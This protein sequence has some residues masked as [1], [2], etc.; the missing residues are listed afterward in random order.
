MH[1]PRNVPV[2]IPRGS[3]FSVLLVITPFCGSGC[4]EWR[5]ARGG[6]AGGAR[7]AVSVY[8]LGTDD[9]EVVDVVSTPEG[10][11][12]HVVSPSIACETDGASSFLSVLVFG[13]ATTDAPRERYL[14]DLGA[15]ES[16]SVAGDP[17]GVY[18]LVTRKHAT[19]P[20][21][22]PGSVL[23][24][25]EG[26]IVRTLETGPSPDAI[27]ISNDGEFAV[28]ACEGEVPDPKDCPGEEG[29]SDLPGSIHI[30]DLRG[31]PESL[32]PV[33]EIGGAAIAGRISTAP[34]GR[35][36][37]AP[38]V[39]PEF[40]AI[41][42]DSRLALVALQ[43]QSAVAVIDLG[44]LRHGTASVDAVLA[45]MV[46][47]Q[48]DH[49][50][51][52]KSVL[53]GT[54]PDGIAISPDGAFAITAN[55]AHPKA[56][57]LQGI[58]ILDLRGGPGLVKLA[59]THAI[60]DLD[61]SLRGSNRNK[62]VEIRPRKKRSQ[63]P[64][65]LPRLDPEGVAIVRLDQ[66]TIAAIAIERT[67]TREEAGSVLLLDVSGVLEGKA[68]S[69]IAR[70]VVGANPGARPE[71]LDFTVDGRHLFVASEQDGGTITLIDVE[72]AAGPRGVDDSRQGKP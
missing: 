27:A 55:E 63:K 51:K 44:P 60:F 2:A 20:G 26:R 69:L 57:H 50:D 71:T 62:P 39:E 1:A 28:I 49:E 36:V 32:K 14:V 13:P 59:G 37:N 7:S 30:I 53:R 11:L 70:H 56:R 47:L 12:V 67:A 72:S 3:F 38:D 5:S 68:P 10:H 29:R 40:V 19:R 6:E 35:E 23:L 25:R 65:S 16:T 18:C 43:E 17:R 66:M 22:G 58:S 21:S 33:I 42:P 9:S 48:H 15:G 61:P 41:S 54:H 24:V 8:D 46:I 31:A 4:M 52:K 34:G 45:G 64:E